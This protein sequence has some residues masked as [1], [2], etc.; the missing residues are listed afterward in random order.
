MD[1][2]LMIPA[3]RTALPRWEVSLE[4]GVVGWV[5]ESKIGRTTRRFFHAYGVHPGTG[6]TVNLENY[7]SLDEAVGTLEEFHEYPDRFKRHF[8]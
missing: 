4:G 7:S 3:T 1:V 8:L 6:A 5:Q 2:R